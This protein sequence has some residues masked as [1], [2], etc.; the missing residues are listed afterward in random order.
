MARSKAFNEE[1]VLD[2]AVEVFWAKGYE[3]A[4]IQD[5]VDAMGIQRGSM[6][7]TFGGKHQLFLTALDRYGDVVVKKLL[8]ILESKSSALESVEQFF[9]QL[10]EHSL[11]AGPLRGC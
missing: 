2:K 4:S 1:I 8:E 5:L 6:Y 11:T 10:V 3:A 7:A 9:S